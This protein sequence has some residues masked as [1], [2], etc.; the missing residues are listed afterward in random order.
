M[1]NEDFR[2]VNGKFSMENENFDF[3]NGKFDV[4]NGKFN[5]VSSNDITAC[6][7]ELLALL[8]SLY[9]LLLEKSSIV[10]SIIDVYNVGDVASPQSSHHL[11]SCAAGS[12]YWLA[13]LFWG[14]IAVEPTR[15]KLAKPASTLYS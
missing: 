3:V 9:T 2:V 15:K 7:R 12:F 13:W 5:V 8:E 10:S 14:I 1:G 11:Q 4:V 6:S